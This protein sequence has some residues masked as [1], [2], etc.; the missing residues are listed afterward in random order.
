[1][2]AFSSCLLLQAQEFRGTVIGHITDSTGAA[3]AGA[4]ITAVGPQQPLTVTS[5]QS[6]D[7]IIPFVTPATYTLTAEQTGFKKE[8]RA[9]IPVDISSR[10]K[11]DFVLQVGS[12][13]ESITVEAGGAVQLDT[14]SASGGTVMDPELTQGLPNSGRMVY[15]LIGLT[16]GAQFTQTQFGANGFSGTRA[17]DENNA[18]SLNG[19]NGNMN[20]FTLN[21]APISTPNGGGNGTWNISPSIDAIEEFKVVMNN[22]DAQYGRYA[23]GTV[24]T[25]LKSGTR[26]YHGSASDNW[27]NTIFDANVY[28]RNQIGLNRLAHNE[29]Q[30]DVTFGGEVIPHHDKLFFFFSYQGY[31]QVQPA[32]VITSVPTAD[33]QPGSGPNGGVDLTGI[34]TFRNEIGP[35][36]PV[37]NRKIGI[38]SPNLP[39]TCIDGTDAACNKWERQPYADNVIPASDITAFASKALALYPKPN[40]PGATYQNN[41]S[42]SG[43][44]THKYN[45]PIASVDYN[46]TPDTKIKFTFAWWSGLEYRNGSGFPGPAANGNINNYRSDV[47]PVV[48]LTHNFGPKL[49]GDLRLGYNRTWD[50]GPNGA[51]SAGLAKLTPGDLGLSMP[52]T[53]TTTR[54]LAP[55]IKLDNYNQ[56][57][58]NTGDP[59]MF[60]TYDLG[61][62]LTHVIGRHNL[63]YGVEYMLFHIANSGV[64]NA[65]GNF[66]FGTGYT[67]ENP[68]HGNSTGSDIADLLL[69]YP[70]GGSVETKYNTYKSYNY[71]AGFFQDD[72]KMTHR[73][74][75]NLGLR[76]DTE[77]SPIDRNNYLMAGLCLTCVNSISKGVTMPG[78][79]PNGASTVTTINGVAEFSSSKLTPYAN[80]WGALQPKFGF[81]YAIT[82]KLVARGGYGLQS[83]EGIELGGA[84]AWDQTTNYNAQINTAI[85]QPSQA[86]NSG[87]PYPNG[88]TKVL[89]NSQGD[90][91]LLGEGIGIDQRDRKLMHTHQYSLN[92]QAQL[93]YGIIGEV[94]YV[95]VYTTN[96]RASRQYNGLSDADVAKEQEL[97]NSYL[98]QAV[99]NPFYGVLPNTTSMGANPTI[100]AKL[101]MVPYPEFN[102]NV[103]IYT[104]ANGWNDYD[105][106]VAK[107]EKRMSNG[108]SLSR[109][110]S[111]LTSFTWAKQWNAQGF[112]NNSG[113]WKVD[114]DKPYRQ[115][116]VGGNAPTWQL[117]FSGLYGMPVG[118]GGTILSTAHGVV[119]ELV[120]DWQLG[121][122]FQNRSGL[123]TSFPNGQPFT[124]GTY[125][126][127]PAHK[128]Y[129]D[130]VNNTQTSCWQNAPTYW[131]TPYGTNNF[132]VR[133]QYAQQTALSMQKKFALKDE[134]NLMFKAEAFNVTNTVQFGGPD[135]GSNPMNGLSRN[136][137][138]A[139][140]NQPGAW[141]GYGTVGSQQQNFPRMMQFTLKLEF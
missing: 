134:L 20:N 112:L 102:G 39:L 141:S 38:Y 21:G 136:T 36:A 50:L 74:A 107:A 4:T 130:W 14:E 133:S 69:G 61:P 52:S 116:D 27:R 31:R 115:V 30:F 60:E 34:L 109:G 58:G 95:G 93:P 3:I 85:W 127:K 79:L 110:L 11:V 120:N 59:S 118:K 103:Y 26:T 125:N 78:T 62:S 71:Y 65:S 9:D 63:H 122:V 43:D 42:F 89:G 100:A 44:S 128:S 45:M 135:T 138:V 105:S 28:D 96:M 92:L 108:G 83:G 56:L 129:S 68:A 121:W 88:L 64:G 75:F 57:I 91:T 137:S 33:M 19:V 23:G 66:N 53:G 6:G 101:L 24:N 48:D 80:T 29:H 114:A 22:Y 40:V 81:T 119:G 15:N 12:K 16:A 49:F 82:P 41:Y 97:G 13:S 47:A 98:D 35:N 2:L 72:W 87:S 8:V 94:G 46:F 104:H 37:P 99:P 18:Y 54:N 77:T 7:Y 70:D 123:G 139:D 131:I 132:K 90:Q 73:L 84:S 86:F 67:W 126:P 117:S 106:M 51:L 76:W 113:A 5:N 140:P 111:F 1:V 55:Q 124:C 10:V 32:G 25:L 17:W